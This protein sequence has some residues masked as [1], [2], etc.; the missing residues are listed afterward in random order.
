MMSAFVIMFFHSEENNVSY[1]SPVILPIFE[2]YSL[3]DQLSVF[4][5]HC[6]FNPPLQK[7]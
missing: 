2:V 6:S 5:L 4:Y 7:A 1:C 3:S